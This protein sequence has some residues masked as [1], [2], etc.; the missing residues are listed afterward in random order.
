[1]E[2]AK[3]CNSLFSDHHSSDGD[4]AFARH[5]RKS[6][7]VQM[8]VDEHPNVTMLVLH[9]NGQGRLA[10]LNTMGWGSF[11]IKIKKNNFAYTIRQRGVHVW[12]FE[13]Q[14]H[15]LLLSMFRSAHQ[16]RGAVHV[17]MGEDGM[18]TVKFEYCSHT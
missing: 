17:L 18:K 12:L 6:T 1:M 11:L 14:L 16:S 3:M 4:G 2:D 7:E 8:R 15:D 9:R 13:Q 5:F 10:I